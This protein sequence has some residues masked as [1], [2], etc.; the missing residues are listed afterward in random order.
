[1]TDHAEALA[2]ALQAI[3]APH[4]NWRATDLSGPRGMNAEIARDVLRAY[5]AAKAQPADS[6]VCPHDRKSCFVGRDTDDAHFRCGTVACPNP[7]NPNALPAQPAGGEGEWVMVPREATADMV[8]SGRSARAEVGRDTGSNLVRACYAAMLVAAPAAPPAIEA[9][10]RPITDEAVQA[11]WS[12]WCATPEVKHA[13]TGE[14]VSDSLVAMRAAL[15]AARTHRSQ[16][17]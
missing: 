6:D 9:Q 15:E 14:P 7:L 8:K 1:M 12:A 13:Q 11:A 3:V 10:W 2:E 16:Q 17:Q 4:G 5:T